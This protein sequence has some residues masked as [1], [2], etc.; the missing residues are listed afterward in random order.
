MDPDKLTVGIWFNQA[1]WLNN[2]LAYIDAMIREVEKAGAN[3]IPVFHLRFKDVSRGNRGAE[4]AAQ[5]FFMKAG[6]SIIDVLISP[7]MFSLTLMDPA[8]K[9]LFASLNVPVIQAMMTMQPFESW[10]AEVQG[11]TTMEVSFSAAQP[12]F[13]AISS[14]CPWP[15]GNRTPQTPLPVP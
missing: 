7:N 10:K 5:T 2:N 13:D 8:C 9:A 4:Y 1:Y 12:E 3:I 6:K 11:M 14:P 15:A